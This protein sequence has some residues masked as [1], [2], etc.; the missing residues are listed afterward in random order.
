MGGFMQPQGH[1]QVVMNTI[2]F[3]L[4]PQAALD[5]P[6]WQWL[7]GRTVEVEPTFPHHLAQA[8]AERGHDLKIALEP[9]SFGRGEII[10][11]DP[12]T[13]VLCGGAETRTD[14]AVAA[15]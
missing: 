3:H 14:G 2:D 6:R 8:L 13:G 11:R 10:W 1:L 7:K 5:A 15:Y 9:N 4:N 12:E